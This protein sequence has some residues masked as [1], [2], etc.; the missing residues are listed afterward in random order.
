MTNEVHPSILTFLI[1]RSSQGVGLLSV[2]RLSLLQ[3]PPTVSLYSVSVQKACYSCFQKDTSAQNVT[4]E[5]GPERVI[6]K[7]S[8]LPIQNKDTVIVCY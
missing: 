8:V 2:H 3:I 6:F 4:I 1:P 5:S 7:K